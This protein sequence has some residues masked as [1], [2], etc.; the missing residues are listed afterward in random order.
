[1]I[2]NKNRKNLLL[3]I[4]VIFMFYSY[5]C[6]ENLKYERYSSKDPEIGVEAD[7]VSG[8]LFSEMRGEGNSFAQVVFYE[9]KKEGEV[10]KTG[11]IITVV[12]AAD[13]KFQPLTVEGM[14]EDLTSKRLKFKDASVLAKE[15]TKILGEEAWDILLSYKTLES[16]YAS[17][18][19]P[20]KERIFLFKKGDKFYSVSYQNTEEDF[21]RIQGA[22]LHL[23]K[24][25]KIK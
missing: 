18:L 23:V 17:K 16:L 3:I 15:K 8:W 19:I 24:S 9:P 25:L 13:V 10:S 2:S 7:H 22:F 5:G 14:A 4:G 21:E 1:M 12:K 11:M 6:G 20:V